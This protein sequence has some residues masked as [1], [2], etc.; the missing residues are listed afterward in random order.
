[1]GFLYAKRNFASLS[2]LGAGGFSP[3]WSCLIW[4]KST[5][6]SRVSLVH[7]TR[8]ATGESWEHIMYGPRDGS[9]N[10][11]FGPSVSWKGLY[12][13]TFI[14]GLNTGC[15]AS[16]SL[17]AACLVARSVKLQRANSKCYLQVI[18]CILCKHFCICRISFMGD[19]EYYID[20]QSRLS[21]ELL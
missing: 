17:S 11:G 9:N 16:F 13:S 1:M 21:T 14:P 18:S 4:A 15:D 8:Y 3:G 7:R 5:D 6:T 20:W 10:F 12:I 19:T 2:N